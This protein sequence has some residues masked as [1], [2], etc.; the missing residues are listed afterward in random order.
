LLCLTS[1]FVASTIANCSARVS[2]YCSS[3]DRGGVAKDAWV[4]RRDVGPKQKA[5]STKHKAQRHSN[6]SIHRSR[7]GK[8]ECRLWFNDNY[9]HYAMMPYMLGGTETCNLCKCSA[10]H[11]LPTLE[12]W[13]W[14][15][16]IRLDQMVTQDTAWVAANLA[17][18]LLN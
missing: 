7:N 3:A 18:C 9:R 16:I 5:Q 12:V 13:W 10:S 2:H 1:A 8:S 17:K 14:L 11:S 15:S 4:E 6:I